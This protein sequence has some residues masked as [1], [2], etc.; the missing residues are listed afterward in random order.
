MRGIRKIKEEEIN[1]DVRVC[2]GLSGTEVW[3]W[4]ER[5]GHC[6]SMERYDDAVAAGEAYRFL[7]A[8]EKKNG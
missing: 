4:V 5:S 3:V 2:Y 6:G 8:K 1:P 7:I